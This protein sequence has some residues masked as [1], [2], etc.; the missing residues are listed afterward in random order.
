MSSR[1][2]KLLDELDQHLN[3]IRSKVLRTSMDEEA[4]PPIEEGQIEGIEGSPE[5]EAIEP[6][7]E[8]KSES[9]LPAEEKEEEMTDEELDELMK[10]HKL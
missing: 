2:I 6:I 10:K 5:E 9:L 7:E 4:K 1:I 8:E 3:V